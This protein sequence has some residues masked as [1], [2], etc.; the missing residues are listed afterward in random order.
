MEVLEKRSVHILLA[1]ATENVPAQIAK[2]RPTGIAG[3]H[4]RAGGTKNETL[5]RLGSSGRASSGAADNVYAPTV[6]QDGERRTALNVD[7][8]VQLP[9]A[10]KKVCDAR[11]ISG[12]LPAL[13]EG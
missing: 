6:G 8:C 11:C 1:S 10:D 7:I 4:R 3:K 2:L 12:V 5:E 9:T 13:A